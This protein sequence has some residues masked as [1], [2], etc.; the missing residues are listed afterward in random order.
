MSEAVKTGSATGSVPT[1]TVG[2][3]TY[4]L[5]GEPVDPDDTDEVNGYDPYCEDLAGSDTAEEQAEDVVYLCG[6][7]V[8]AETLKAH[9]LAA[10]ASRG[11][12]DCVT[13]LDELAGRTVVVFPGIVNGEKVVAASA[14][15]ALSGKVA[16]SQVLVL[17][18]E[19]DE[20]A[21]MQG[22]LDAGHSARELAALT[23]QSREA[24]E[25]SPLEPSAEDEWASLADEE[26]T[27]FPLEVLPT[28]MRDYVQAGA[29]SIGCDPAL[30]APHLLASFAAAIGNTRR[31][32]I[33][34]GWDEPPVLWMATVARSGDKKS[35]GCDYGLK[36]L[37]AIQYEL[38]RRW[39]K[40]A[41]QYDQDV[42]A[43][44]SATKQHKGQKASAPPPQEPEPPV[45]Q[46]IV[47]DDTTVEA[48]TDV[49]EINPRGVICARDELSAWLGAFDRY[50]NLRG[51][52]KP[53]WLMMYGARP[54]SVNRK[55]TEKKHTYVP[56]AAVCL[57]GNI[58]PSVLRDRI[59]PD[60]HENGLLARLMFCMPP[61]NRQGMTD[62]VVPDAVRDR[63]VAVCKE[64]HALEF[65]K[66]KDGDQ[67]PKAIPLSRAAYACFKSYSRRNKR[68]MAQLED[69]LE[70]ASSKFEGAVARFALVL[71]CTWRAEH[72]V[73]RKDWE[74]QSRDGDGDGDAKAADDDQNRE[75]KTPWERGDRAGDLRKAKRE[76]W[77]ERIRK[78]GEVA[79]AK[80]EE[81][82]RKAAEAAGKSYTPVTGRAEEISLVE[83]EAAIAL[84]DFF[85]RE[86]TRV[87]AMMVES[88]TTAEIKNLV[89]LAKANG[90][91]VSPRELMTKRNRYRGDSST[92]YEALQR[93]ADRGLA[94]WDEDPN[95]R[96][97]RPSQFIRLTPAAG[98]PPGGLCNHS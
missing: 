13:H 37:N 86:A 16:R 5:T 32:R 27:P 4:I 54:L 85:K 88:E 21:G 83:V 52:D 23:A 75:G 47:V 59:G 78:G 25:S 46:Q 80:L 26:W 1:V 92:A 35:P 51:A 30:I 3:V 76:V 61:R 60:D 36:P 67:Y 68:E 24:L 44:K 31:A 11:L 39:K 8:D 38:H 10:V 57:C 73:D 18:G 22:W 7:E 71:H 58:P 65:E 84:V 45:E 43:Y 9:G 49:L 15:T 90:G 55:T 28:S 66:G 19:Y 72:E 42:A 81:R 64:L 63:A 93:L 91:R 40:D 62:S 96:G 6:N 33:K 34:R 70:A 14:L 20:S 97:G 17:P 82:R 74:A 53:L 41:E 94:R 29:D 95:P 48:L 12:R 77:Q 79:V 69:A 2:N 87:Y 50:K 56:R 89:E 98:G